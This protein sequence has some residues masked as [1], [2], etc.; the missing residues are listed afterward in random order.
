MTT[1][2]D[3]LVELVTDQI[4]S[5]EQ[6]I[7]DDEY[8][9]VHN[10]LHPI[11]LRELKLDYADWSDAELQDYYCDQLGVDI[12]SSPSLS[13]TDEEEE[14]DIEAYFGKSPSQETANRGSLPEPSGVERSKVSDVHSICDE[15]GVAEMAATLRGIV[16]RE[17]TVHGLQP[18]T[19]VRIPVRLLLRLV[20]GEGCIG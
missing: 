9:D 7:R 8:Q 18:T 13:S 6:M 10:W 1:R 5:I 19:E 3:M 17:E 2:H 14:V 4:N 11:L 16:S 20:H 12:P 15:K